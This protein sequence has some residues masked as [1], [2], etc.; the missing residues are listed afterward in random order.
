MKNQCLTIWRRNIDPITKVSFD[1]CLDTSISVWQP[2]YHEFYPLLKEIERRR[3]LCKIWSKEENRRY[4]T[5]FSRDLMPW[6]ALL[7][8]SP[9][10]SLHVRLSSC[11]NIDA[12]CF[13]DY[14]KKSKF[15]TQLVDC[16]KIIHDLEH[17]EVPC[18]TKFNVMYR[19]EEYTLLYEGLLLSMIQIF[20]KHDL[21]KMGPTRAR[22]VA[23][24]IFAAGHGMMGYDLIADPDSCN[25]MDLFKCVWIWSVA[26]QVSANS[27]A[28][29]H[30]VSMK[31]YNP[32]KYEGTLSFDLEHWTT[33]RKLYNIMLDKRHHQSSRLMKS[34]RSKYDQ[35]GEAGVIRVNADD[36]D[37]D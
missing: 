13:A 9:I 15:T 34:M 10:Q 1:D 12:N 6:S 18:D 30:I 29:K 33:L 2:T 31:D 21:I 16:A 23:A 4:F 11:Y 24:T 25:R 26:I 27:L 8:E 3:K 20:L 28:G 22:L 19:G 5:S 35:D 36:W 7:C 37:E 14:E 17:K 32:Y